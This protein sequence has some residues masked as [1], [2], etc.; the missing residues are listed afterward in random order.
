MRSGKA[1]ES[2]SFTG[3]PFTIDVAIKNASPA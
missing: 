3:F 1:N 2:I